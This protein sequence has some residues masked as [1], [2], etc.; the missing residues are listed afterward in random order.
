MRSRQ[1]LLTL[2]LASGSIVACGGGSGGAGTSDSGTM[3]GKDGGGTDSGTS[4]S[5]STTDSGSGTDTGGGTGDSSSPPDSSGSE[6]GMG[7]DG[8]GPADTTTTGGHAIKTVFII[9]M[10][11]TNWSS[12]TGD[13]AATYINGTLV[14][15]YGHANNYKNPPNIH[16]S[17]P[18]YLW[19]EAATNFNVTADADPDA[20]NI[21][22]TTSHVVSQ[23]TTAGVSWKAYVEGISGATCPLTRSGLFV[24]RHTP[25]LYFDDVTNNES[26]TSA[27]CISHVVPYT[28]LATDLTGNSV[29]RYNFITPNLCDD[30]H[31]TFGCTNAFDAVANGDAWLT[32]NIPPI[33][34]STAYK[35]GGVIF[36]L[37]DEGTLS[38]SD[39]PIGLIVLSPLL[40]SAG[41]SNTIAYTHSSM[42]KSIEEIFSVP[43][44]NDAAT[45]T[46]TDLAD[47]F[48]S[49]P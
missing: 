23:L 26:A 40:K 7:T 17:L 22:S 31:N 16:P 15:M 37:W 1:F 49:F 4:D 5:S 33:L 2:A 11:N 43:L 30:M 13:A 28:N 27:N 19:L 24:P 41:Y 3:P 36:I 39:G 44:L 14:P 47:F 32:T 21:Q 20:T 46:T 18:N 6:T 42:V 29:A 35:D 8:S 34:A 48:T 10:E 25:M 38:L 9:M 45:A 12:V